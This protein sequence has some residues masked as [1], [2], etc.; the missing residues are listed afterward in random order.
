MVEELQSISVSS[1][2]ATQLG[3]T[4]W[5]IANGLRAQDPAARLR[6]WNEAKPAMVAEAVA[7]RE[8]RK[9]RTGRRRRLW[10]ALVQALRP[11][12]EPKRK[13]QNPYQTPAMLKKRWGVHRLPPGI[14]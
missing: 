5:S 2:E 14:A 6:G 3:L 1:E 8:E 11:K 9:A 7:E 12:K 13:K 4:F 10:M